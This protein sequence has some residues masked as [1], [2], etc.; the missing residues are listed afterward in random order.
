MPLQNRVRPDGEIFAIDARGTLMGNRGGR[1]HING[2]RELHSSRRWAS[3]QWISCVTQFKGRR[4]TP[5]SDNRYTE[6][7]FLDE[8]TALAAGHRPC[9]ECRRSAAVQFAEIWKHV[10][11]L[12]QRPKAKDIDRALHT[13]RLAGR[14]KWTIRIPFESLPSGAMAMDGD[15]MVAKTENRALAWSFDGYCEVA[16]PRGE[17]DCLTPPAILKVLKGQYSPIWHPSAT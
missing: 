4:R 3:R 7:F 5:M 17:V 16:P 1:L 2:K 10:F 14:K 12:D 15:R 11:H 8:V 9:F 6:L 13:E